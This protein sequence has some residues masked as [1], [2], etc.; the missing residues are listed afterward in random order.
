MQIICSDTGC[1]GQGESKQAREAKEVKQEE[2]QAR[3][4]SDMTADGK[5][6]EYQRVVKELK[7]VKSILAGDGQV[8]PAVAA[9][10]AQSIRSTLAKSIA[11]CLVYS[12]VRTLIVHNASQV[13][14]LGVPDLSGPQAIAKDCG[15][16]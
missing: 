8:D 13:L 10:E 14:K 6:A 1:S 9:R 4:F 15:T 3:V 2:T 7:A 11:S 12:P 16:L 5:L